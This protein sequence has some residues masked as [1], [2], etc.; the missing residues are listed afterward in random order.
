MKLLYKPF[1]VIASLISARLGR[2]LFKSLW[3]RL[4]E[5]D[6]PDPTTHQASLPKVVGAAALEAATLAGIAAAVSRGSARAFEYLT[7][8]WPGD[9]EAEKPED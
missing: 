8:Y 2:G 9:E 4:D 6:P 5:R 7:G 3:S 1:A